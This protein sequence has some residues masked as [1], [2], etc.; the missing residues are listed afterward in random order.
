METITFTTVTTTTIEKD[1]VPSGY[2]ITS[3]AKTRA[4]KCYNCQAEFRATHE[5]FYKTQTGW[6]CR[7]PICDKCCYCRN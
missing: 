2:I 1:S 5:H 6:G 7:C 3:P 4:F